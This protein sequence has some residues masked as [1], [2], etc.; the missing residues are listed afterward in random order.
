MAAFQHFTVL[1]KTDSG[2]REQAKFETVS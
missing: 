2:S 1:Y